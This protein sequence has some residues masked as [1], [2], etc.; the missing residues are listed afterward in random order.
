MTFRELTN[1]IIRLLANH[2]KIPIVKD[3]QTEEEPPMPYGY[4][5]VL[6]HRQQSTD[7]GDCFYL[8]ENDHITH[9]RQEQVNAT[10]SFTFVSQSRDTDSGYIDGE[11]EA[12]ELAE[13]AVSF[14]N[15]VGYFELTKAGIVVDGIMDMGDRTFLKVDEMCY[16]YGFDVSVRYVRSEKRKE[17]IVETVE[18]KKG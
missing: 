1:S 9:V 7:F 8:P 16:E 3:N 10:F 18:A 4:Y 14:F 11:E 6:S 5:S 2:L 17:G 15:H 13:K 12:L